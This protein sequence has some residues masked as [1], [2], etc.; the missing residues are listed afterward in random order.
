MDSSSIPDP[1]EEK[2][3]GVEELR[4]SAD[5]LRSLGA[6]ELATS[7]TEYADQYDELLDNMQQVGVDIL[8]M[9]K[10]I[11]EQQEKG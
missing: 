11:N 8:L 9:F 5:K 2:R 6:K 10:A 7:A 3:K 4:D 1:I